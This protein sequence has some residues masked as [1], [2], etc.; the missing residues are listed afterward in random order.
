[1]DLADRNIRQF[2]QFTYSSIVKSK[3]CFFLRFAIFIIFQQKEPIPSAKWE[4][5]YIQSTFL[6][7]MW[8][9]P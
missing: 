7:I 4:F 9:N 3:M 8:I 6:W 5:T 2:C 1:M